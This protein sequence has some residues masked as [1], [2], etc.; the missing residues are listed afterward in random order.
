MFASTTIR[1]TIYIAVENFLTDNGDMRLPQMEFSMQIGVAGE[2]FYN[3]LVKWR[4]DNYLVVKAP[5]KDQADILNDRM[6]L[7]NFHQANYEN[8]LYFAAETP[9]ELDKIAIKLNKI[10][11]THSLEGTFKC[12]LAE[13]NGTLDYWNITKDSIELAD[14]PL[15]F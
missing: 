11:T 15:I 10:I 9:I 14:A 4:I 12:M 1:N 5:T 8:V 6:R 2:F 13:E 3:A 7:Y